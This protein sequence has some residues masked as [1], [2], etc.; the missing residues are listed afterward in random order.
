[1]AS[2][3]KLRV[4]LIHHGDAFPFYHKLSGDTIRAYWYDPRHGTSRLIGE[5]KKAE[6]Q[7]FTPPSTGQGNDWVLVLDDAS[8]NYPPPGKVIQAPQ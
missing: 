8:K 6:Y 7:D 5:F 3:M 1:M 4:N 2:G